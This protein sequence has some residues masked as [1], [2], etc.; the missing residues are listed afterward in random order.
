MMFLNSIR[1]RLQLWHGLLLIIVLAGFGVTAYQL[2]RATHLRRI[3][4]ELQQ[5]LSVAGTLTRRPNEGPGRP[6]FEHFSTPNQR[7]EF[8]MLPQNQ[9]SMQG[10]G[11]QGGGFGASRHSNTGPEAPP[12]GNADRGP[13]DPDL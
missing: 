1:W 12:F 4:D 3:D 2:Q 5:R 13:R 11:K 8:P 10:T 7:P 9:G 6:P